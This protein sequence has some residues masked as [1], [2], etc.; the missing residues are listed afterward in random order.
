MKMF[1]TLVIALAVA[2]AFVACKK[3]EAATEAAPAVEE[4]APVEAAAP[5][6]GEAAAPVEGEVAPAADATAAQPQ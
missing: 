6:E 3:E 2:A 4:T 1:K 5:A